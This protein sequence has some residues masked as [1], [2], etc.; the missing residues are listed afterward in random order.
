MLDRLSLPLKLVGIS[1]CAVA[2]GALLPWASSSG[3]WIWGLQAKGGPF[4]LAVS[5]ASLLLL[6]AHVGIGPLNPGPRAF[7]ISQF[8]ASWSCLVLVFNN[9]STHPA[10]GYYL[11]LLG[12][13]VWLGSAYWEWR[14]RFSSRRK[15]WQS[16][17]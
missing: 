1:A 16:A 5:L 17:E 6:L 10:L 15:P 3:T 11:S 14:R 7:L 2:L 13:L 12:G 9:P 8:L 4:N